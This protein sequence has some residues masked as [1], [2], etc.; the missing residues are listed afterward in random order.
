MIDRVSSWIV[1]YRKILL[2]LISIIAIGFPFVVTSKYI[3]R[4]VTL[5]MIYCTLAV[6]LN[7]MVGIMGQM[8]FGHAA[9]WGIGAYTA[10]ILAK[11][12][13]FTN[14]IILVLSAIV[15]GLFGLL[16]SLPVM[17]LKGYYF[18]IVTM[19]FCQIIRIIEINW[20]S[21]TNGP[22]GIMAIPK[23]EWF[24]TKIKG[25]TAYY[26][27]ILA[28]LAFS[29]I[30]VVLIKN[31]R[32]G[33][34]IQA[35]RDD[36]IAA[37]A[38]GINIFKY[39]SITIVISSMLAGLAGG[40]YAIYSSYIDPNCFTNSV[41]NN[42]LVMVIFGG[43]GNVLG[44]FIGAS[45]LTILPE[46]LRGF[47]AYRQLVYGALLVILMLVRSEGLL[48]SVNFKYIRQKMDMDKETEGATH[49]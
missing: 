47:S 2:I 44:S 17:H 4:L 21:L 23:M 7:L 26:F 28:I 8:S 39:K 40:F 10:A 16:L 20:I 49:E 35:I 38:M 32:M 24:G 29:T 46:V 18:T 12:Y 48:G 42:I 14:P 22:L 5:C 15:A 33:Y 31:S 34:A 45:L 13:G 3:M 11:T 25:V 1:K 41:S 36:D 19:V 30:V 27:L 37:C 6:S 43:M 9:F